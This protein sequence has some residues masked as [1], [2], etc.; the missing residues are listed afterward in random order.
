VGIST[1]IAG[2]IIA[3]AP[4]AAG[5]GGTFVL[6]KPLVWL[7]GQFNVILA[8]GLVNSIAIM[9]CTFG[10]FALNG[11][12]EWFSE[13]TYGDTK[14]HIQIEGM[15]F[16][17]LQYENTEKGHNDGTAGNQPIEPRSFYDSTSPTI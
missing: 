1:L 9:A 12:R 14:T 17:D 15:D 10:A 7:L 6:A 4:L 5:L 8:P 3:L 11:I 13:K 16:V 2:C